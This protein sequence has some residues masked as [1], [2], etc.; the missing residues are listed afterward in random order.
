MLP[1]TTGAFARVL[2]LPYRLCVAGHQLQTVARREHRIQ[3]PLS[4]AV[5]AAEGD[6]TSKHALAEAAGD[7]GAAD[8]EDQAGNTTSPADGTAHRT[9]DMNAKKFRGEEA[10]DDAH[11]AQLERALNCACKDPDAQL[12]KLRGK[13]TKDNAVNAALAGYESGVE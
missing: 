12:I 8:S 13:Y 3:H 9:P 5:S 7:G 2:P 4:P 10:G 11:A 6:P 1:G